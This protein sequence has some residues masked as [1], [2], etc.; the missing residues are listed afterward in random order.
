M[1]SENYLSTHICMYD[2]HCLNLSTKTSLFSPGSTHYVLWPVWS[3]ILHASI[4]FG[5][6]TKYVNKWWNC[7]GIKFSCILWA[8]TLACYAM[9]PCHWYLHGSGKCYSF[10]GSGWA[11]FEVKIWTLIVDCVKVIFLRCLAS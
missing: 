2:S 3:F 7:T 11:W 9:A 1:H 10:W 4:A 8:R 6:C 5:N